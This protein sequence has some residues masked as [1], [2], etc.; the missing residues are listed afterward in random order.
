MSSQKLLLN[1]SRKYPIR[2]VV[3]VILGFSGAIFNGIS[4]TLIVPIILNILGVQA[5]LKD[6][7]AL[8]QNIMSPFDSVPEIY[9]L[10]LM[11]GAILLAIILKNLTNYV[12]SLASSALTRALTA[13]MRESG[14][15]LLLN[16]DLDYYSQMKVGDIVNRLGGEISRASSTISTYIGML[17]TSI[18]ILVFVA[19]LLAISWQLTL[20]ATVLLL[21]VTAI[22]QVIV[23]RSKRFGQKLSELSRGYSIKLLEILNGIRLVKSTG[24][25]EQEYE[26]VSQLI[27]DREKADFEEQVNSA[28]I[29]PINEVVNILVILFLVMIGR[30]FLQEQVSS[31][32]TVLLTYLFVLFR[33]LPLIS[34]LN[35]SRSQA[36]NKS[37]SV[38]IVHDFLRQD[39]KS[40]MKNGDQEF[41]RLEKEIHF[42]QISF[43]YPGHQ[44][45]VLKNIDLHLQR[46]TTLALVGGSGSG[47]STLASLLPRFYDPTQGAVMIDGKDLRDFDIK[48][49]R[50]AM[51]IVSQDTFL[52]NASVRYNLAYAKPDATEEQIIDAAKRANAYEFIENLPQGL[53]TQIGDRGVL[54]SG[55]QRQRLAIAR[56]LLQNPDILILD[57]ATSALD[58]V[59]ERLVQE[60]IEELSRERTTLVIA[61]RLSTI[62]KADQ[63]AVLDEGKVAEVGSHD[64]LLAQGGKYARL[65]TL[66]FADEA[67]RDQAIIKSSYDVRTRLNPMIGFLQLLSED[68]IDEPEEREELLNES[69]HSA[70]HILES[71]EFIEQSVKLRL[72]KRQ[73]SSSN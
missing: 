62:Q 2:I 59:S 56:A 48:S 5:N 45:M 38:E 61:H 70:T 18:T 39:N 3:I 35:S 63:I 51:G 20:V 15:R 68:M 55:G 4:T 12:K 67:E 23:N 65:Y 66:Q 22:N 9:R 64:E 21:L 17:I 19:M 50:K 36:A 44:D 6:A 73:E 31:L 41:K 7:P 30:I 37:A 60:A 58:T 47:K 69:Y 42:N 54:L 8:I 46:G 40:F 53:D 11:T 52:F 24:N 26:Q 25:E 29:G 1:F 28:A 16:V 71:L 43:A 10:P 32:A 27:R 57:E 13:D 49:I 34:G 14:L 33:T 72:S